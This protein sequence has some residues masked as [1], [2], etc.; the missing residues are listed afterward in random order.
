MKTDVS[1][2]IPAYNERESIPIL[3]DRLAKILTK[4]KRNWEAIL[5][6]D[7]STDG[8]GKAVDELAK[9][10]RVKAL[11][12]N[13]N[14]GKSVALR[15]GFENAAGEV[16][17]MLDADLQ[18]APEDIPKLLEMIDN[19]YDAV[20]GWR[21]NRHDPFTRKVASG[22]Y[23]FLTR[24]IFGLEIRDFNSGLKAFRRE[25]VEN[26]GLRSDFHRYILPLAYVLGLKVGEVEIQH[27]PREH[28]E[29]KYGSV[30]RLIPGILDLIS[31]KLQFKFME[32]PM[33]LLGLSG[34]MLLMLG[35]FFGGYV[36]VLKVLYH[37][38]FEHHLAMLMLSVL[39]II[40]GLQSFF[41]GF[42][43]DIFATT[44]IEL[45][46]ELRRGKHPTGRK[47]GH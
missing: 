10:R 38:P 35:G 9:T 31:L 33:T 13:R 44:R 17:V 43:A 39:L 34:I 1:V 47:R 7:G 40:A 24:T 21:K 45:L 37:Q 18:Y 19:G 22:V 20:N 46:E 6:D 27:F 23:N 3:I 26:V 5:V 2:V 32:K 29:T 25:V 8:T 30:Y 14:M 28:G 16:I 11:H 36:V 4:T 12:H 42:L 15:T 41:F